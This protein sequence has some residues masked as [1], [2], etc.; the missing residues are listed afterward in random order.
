MKSLRFQMQNA[1]IGTLLIV[2]FGFTLRCQEFHLDV[3][4]SAKIL[5]RISLADTNENVIV[6]EG[7]G[8]SITNGTSN[9]IIGFNAAQLNTNGHWNVFAGR[10]AG[11][12]NLDGSFNVF[13]GGSS[14]ISNRTGE[15]NVFLGRDTGFRNNSGSRNVFVGDLAGFENSDASNNVFVGREAGYRNRVDGIIGIGYLAL[16]QNTFSDNTTPYGTEN[17]AIGT[18][19]GMMND[20][21]YRNTFIGYMTGKENITGY[22]NVALGAHSGKNN[23]GNH[24]TFLGTNSGVTSTTG[25]NN[26]II[27]SQADV[28][29]GD[30]IN[31]TAIGANAIVGQSNSLVLGNNANVGIGVISPESKLHIVGDIKIVDGTQGLGK[32]LTSDENGEASW[33]S[34]D[35]SNTNEKISELTIIGDSLLLTE[36]TMTWTV[37]V[38]SSN[39]NEIQSLTSVLN[40]GNDGGGLKIS[41]IADPMA[42]QDAAT[43]AYV[44]ALLREIDWLKSLLGV[45]EMTDTEGN[46]YPTIQ[47]GTQ[48]WMAKNLNVGTMIDSSSDQMDNG[49]IQKYCYRDLDINCDVYG[50]LYQWDEMMQYVI[51]EGA[52]GICPSGWHIPTD[53]EWTTLTDY[54]GGLSVAG[55]KMKETGLVHWNS[56]NTDA[57]NESGFTGLP[58]GYRSTFGSFFQIGGG[59]WWWSSTEQ[60]DNT[61]GVGRRLAGSVGDAFLDNSLKQNGFSVRCLKD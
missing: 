43:K 59:G 16:S 13:I 6:G 48:F 11:L 17:T 41:N 38:D 29:T 56:P 3:E 36:G 24:N 47:I 55:G 42:D 7:A 10:N 52:Q 53:S 28:A 40:Q 35:N 58:G 46:T 20:V 21:G 44:D 60:A 5:G 50:G 9:T 4:G 34:N 26:T 30:L 33:Q 49:T 1:F 45:G 37:K 12:L 2:S 8:I 57:T 22:N 27:G 51:T 14:G 15:A 25:S 18:Y 19:S 31:A 61:R 54:L 23:L 39:T 32:V